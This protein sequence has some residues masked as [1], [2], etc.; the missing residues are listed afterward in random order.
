MAVANLYRTV[1]ASGQGPVSMTVVYDTVSLQVVEFD[2][3]N[4]TGQPGTFSLT[5]PVNRTVVA[6]AADARTV[7]LTSHN[8]VCS[9][10]Q[11]TDKYG[12]RTITQLPGGEAVQFIWPT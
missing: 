12:T 9:Q 3:N 4:P 5:G 7:D 6:P 10:Q 2:Y 8:L 11:V 1:F